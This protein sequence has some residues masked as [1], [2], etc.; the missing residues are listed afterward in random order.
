VLRTGDAAVG[1]G[2]LE[3]L[4]A[5]YKDTPVAPDLMGLWQKLGV[6]PDGSGVRLNDAAPLA[7]T[8]HAIMRPR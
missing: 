6:E 4:Y 2:V 1:T 3:E 7:A 8:R 5:K